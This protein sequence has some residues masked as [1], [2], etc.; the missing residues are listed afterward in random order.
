MINELDSAYY[1]SKLA[2]EKLPGN[3]V[4]FANHALSLVTRGDSVEL[5]NIYDKATFKRELHDEIYL[6]AM[7]DII[8]KDDS[9]FA[10]ENFDLNVESGNENLKRSYYTLKIGKG[11]MITA[12]NLNGIGDAYF[13][14]KDFVNA[15]RFFRQASE[16]NPYELPYAENY[17]NTKLKLGKFEEALVILDD[18]I[19]IKES[20]S[21][22]AKYMRVLAY[23]NLEDTDK[24]CIYIE[25]I[26]D[27]PLFQNLELSRF[28][29]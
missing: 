15:E 2:F 18:L 23:L 11:D 26:K 9:N 25:E 5:A 29:N 14:N 16:M 3:V 20:K 13:Q 27:Y 12:A 17:A 21:L 22:I 8:N 7:A 6:T 4:H 28:C 19:D 1:F 24:A 10:L